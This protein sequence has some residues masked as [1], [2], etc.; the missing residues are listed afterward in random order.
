MNFDQLTAYLDRLYQENLPGCDMLVYKDHQVV[1]RHF[2]G[3]R[4]ENGKEPMQ[5]NEIFSIY[6]CT[7]LLTT[8]AAMQLLEQGKIFLDDPVSDYL[9]AYAHLTV[10]D[11]DSVR[12]AQKVMTVRHLMSMQSGLNYNLQAAPL[13]KLIARNPMATTR[14]ITE[15]LAEGPLEFDPGTNYLYSLSHDVLAAVI[16]VASGEKFSDYLKAHIFDPLGLKEIAFDCTE[17]MRS[18]LCAKFVYHAET[19]SISPTPAEKIAYRLS[20]NHES[21]GAG[22][23]SSLTDYALFLDAIACGGVGYTGARI[24]SPE[25]I[26][27]WRSNQLGPVSRKSYEVDS[28]IGYS[29]ALGVR[30]RMDEGKNVKTSSEEF[31]WGGAAG[32]HA[33]IDTKHRMSFF[34]APHVLGRQR[35][36]LEVQPELRRLVYEAMEL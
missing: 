13:Q 22:L 18:R 20:P 35:T 4:D 3:H 24:L 10:K 14:E 9:P 8:C 1:Y 11:G 30:C 7:K 15:A 28:K 32:A 36:S 16:E 23:Y 19:D 17:D 34:F 31:G 29:Y 12:P 5:G 25:M 27:L 21:G 6:S 26:Q 2:S 33:V